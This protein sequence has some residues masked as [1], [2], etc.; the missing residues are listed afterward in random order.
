MIK[1]KIF[2]VA[3]EGNRS[4][5]NN[6]L[7]DYAEVLIHE[8]YDIVIIIPSIGN[9][10]AECHQRGLK[11][12]LFYYAGVT[13]V[14]KGGFFNTLKKIF[15]NLVTLVQFIFYLRKTKPN[16]VISNSIVTPAI[17][18]LASK[19]FR[20]PHIWFIQEF[21]DKDHNLIFDFGYPLTVRIIN[22]VSDKVIA[23]SDAVKNHLSRFIKPDKIYVILNRVAV[24]QKALFISEKK[25]IPFRVL[26]LSQINSGKNQLEGVMAIDL[27]L[28]KGLDIELEM[29]GAILD[30]NYYGLIQNYISENR[31]EEKIYFSGF[32]E[33]PYKKIAESNLCILCSKC[34][35]CS[36]TIFEVLRIGTPIIVS[37]TGGNPE[38]IKD[39]QIG[40]VYEL[41]NVEDLANKIELLYY[42]PSYAEELSLKGQKYSEMHYNIEKSIMQ[43]KEIFNSVLYN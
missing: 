39:T 12:K 33:E 31:S 22:L 41:S 24:K 17:F 10:V 8:D 38:I 19:L 25:H 36:L 16:I 35:A 7:L 20:I 27:L 29:T 13:K 26:H 4:G 30:Y 1:K 11:T 42:N 3:H 14:G 37:N 23:V 34:E 5:A 21:G 6:A 40:L 32:T 43:L 2:W 18:G 15:R 28:K 9:L